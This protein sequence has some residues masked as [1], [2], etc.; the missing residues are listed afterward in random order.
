MAMI[1]LIASYSLFLDV[2]NKASRNCTGIMQPTSG[3]RRDLQA[4]ISAS[5][6]FCSQ[7]ESTPAPP[8]PNMNRQQASSK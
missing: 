5:S 1:T 3:I 7:V 2:P 6:F 8:K 4:L